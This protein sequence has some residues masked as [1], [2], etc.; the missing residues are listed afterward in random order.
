YLNDEFFYTAANEPPNPTNTPWPSKAAAPTPYLSSNGF[1]VGGPSG[2]GWHKMLDF[3]EVPSPAFKA[4]GNVAL[5]TN[6]DWARQDLR[7]GLLN[8]NLIVDEEVFL[9]LMGSNLYGVINNPN[10]GVLNAVQLVPIPNQPPRT[11]A[12][13]TMVDDNGSPIF[14][15]NMPNVGILDS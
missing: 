9:G 8:I 4:I 2:A 6:Y 14:N 12:V 10:Q 3:F 5:G 13:V 1:Y 7:P 15:Y 11:P